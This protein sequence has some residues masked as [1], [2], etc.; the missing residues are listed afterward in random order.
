M[1][2]SVVVIGSI[3]MIKGFINAGDLIAYLLYVTTFIATVRRIIEFSEQFQRGMTGIERF[4]EIVD[5]DIEIFDE[6][7]AKDIENAKGDIEF[8]KVSFEYPDDHNQVFKN[9]DFTIKQGEKIAF[10]GPSGGGKTTL[11]NLI[12]R[13]Y[14]VTDGEIY[15]D[16]QNI[17]QYTLKS[18]RKSI[19]MVQQDVYLFSGTVYEN[20]AYGK[21]GA[22]YEEVIEAAKKAGA[23]EFITALKDGYDTYVG[24]RGVKLS[25]G[26]KQ[27]ISIARV[28]LK[29]PPIIILDEA[30]SAL[31]NESEFAVA[32]SLN[33]LSV[34]R[35]TITVAHRL[36]TIRNADRIMVLTEEGI[37]EQGTH[38]ELL[39]LGGIYTKFNQ[40]A[41]ELQ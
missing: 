16:G 8:K 40:M 26:Q 37:V 41:S 14:D 20:I 4:V 6:P 11:C 2:S 32:K 3:F 33:K 34:G 29:N 18:L 10:V 39:K 19:G 5:A 7:D 25:G 24:E 15:L 12:P 17:K 28:F 22:T 36:S 35:T 38:D 9:L 27:R 30:T 21:P 13:F 23:D 31:D 1:Y